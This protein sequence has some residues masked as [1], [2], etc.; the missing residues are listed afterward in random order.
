VNG[1]NEGSSH[2][3]RKDFFR[4]GLQ[5]DFSKIFPGVQTVVKFVFS[6]SKLRKQPLLNFQ[7]PGWARPPV[8]P[9][10]SDAPGSSVGNVTN[11]TVMAANSNHSSQ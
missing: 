11:R 8:P 5:W 2:G 3:R 4:G 10:P 6:H 9:S 7:N 1:Q